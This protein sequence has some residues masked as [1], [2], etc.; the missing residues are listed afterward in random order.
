MNVELEIEFDGWHAL[1]GLE[2]H[3]MRVAEAALAGQPDAGQVFLL[4]TSDADIQVMNRKW[5]NKDRPTN[6]LS[7]P[8]AE[9]PVPNGEVALLGDVVL[10]YETVEREAA[11]QGKTLTAHSSHLIVH[12]ILH[13]L[14]YDHETDADANA[15]ENEERRILA[16]LDIADPYET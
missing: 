3:A 12:G 10:A 13:L 4:F 8:A 9:M 11:E 15:M 16:D 1:T 14:G 6:V 5:R 7:F 2:E